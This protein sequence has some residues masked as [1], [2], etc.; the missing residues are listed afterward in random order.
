MDSKYHKL[1]STYFS[2]HFNKQ[3]PIQLTHSSFFFFSETELRC[4]RRLAEMYCYLF[5]SW[6]CIVKWTWQRPNSLKK[7]KKKLLFSSMH[8]IFSKNEVVCVLTCIISAWYFSCNLSKNNL[9]EEN[10]GHFKGHWT[11]LVI[12]LW[13]VP[14]PQQWNGL[15]HCLRVLIPFPL[16]FLSVAFR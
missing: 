3:E 7:P 15:E 12:L 9:A 6:S 8:T 2:K 5:I 14:E 10:E 13:Y 11:V 16:R 4:I 1:L